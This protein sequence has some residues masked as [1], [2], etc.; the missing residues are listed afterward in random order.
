MQ[1]RDNL[2]KLDE[3]GGGQVSNGKQLAS[4]RLHKTCQYILTFPLYGD[5]DFS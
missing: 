4:K 3:K 5:Q 2:T 1:A